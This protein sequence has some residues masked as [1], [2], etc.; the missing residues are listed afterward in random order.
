M[1]VR[2]RP[3]PIPGGI[4]G[5]VQFKD[6]NGDFAGVAGFTYNSLTGILTIPGN[7][8]GNLLVPDGGTTELTTHLQVKEAGALAVVSSLGSAA[9]FLISGPGNKYQQIILN[10][11]FSTDIDDGFAFLQLSEGSG[12]IA[13]GGGPETDLP[14][15][16][17]FDGVLGQ[18]SPSGRWYHE[19]ELATADAGT[20]FIHELVTQVTRTDK[21]ATD[22]LYAGF[23]TTTNYGQ[24]GVAVL[25]TAHALTADLVVKGSGS[26]DSEV[27]AISSNVRCDIGTGFTQAAGPVGRLWGWDFHLQGPKAVQPDL[28]NGLTILAENFYNGSPADSPSAALW[29]VSQITGARGTT[30]PMDVGLGI[31]GATGAAGATSAFTIGIDIGRLGSGWFEAGTPKIGT[32]IRVNNCSGPDLDLN[33]YIQGTEINTPAA[34]AANS[35]RLFAKDNGS[36]KTQLMVIFASGAAQQLAIQP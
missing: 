25:G 32:G 11:A 33:G 10:T 21:L 29:L 20:T 18:I 34:G 23:R 13:L 14:V 12:L 2:T 22:Q 30:Y 9:D 26:S 8:G 19:Q 35:Y 7:V 1:A 4:S 36:G 16:L 27:A 15:I 24:G 5:S 31:G 6:A 3:D 28:L 17:T